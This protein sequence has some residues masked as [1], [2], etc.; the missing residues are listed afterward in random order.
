MLKHVGWLGLLLLVMPVS[1]VEP[2]FSDLGSDVV[3]V[4]IT[5]V[6]DC[7]AACGTRSVRAGDVLTAEQAEKLELTA[8]GKADRTAEVVYLPVFADGVGQEERVSVFLRGTEDEKPV[9]QDSAVETYKNIAV[10]AAPHCEDPEGGEL[11]YTVVRAPKRGTVTWQA[12]GTF[13]Y[14]PKDE[15]VGEDYFTYVAEDAAGN[16][17]AEAKVSVTILQCS[18]SDVFADMVG[19]PQELAAVFLRKHDIF[20]GTEIGE[21]TCFCPEQ[22]VSY[23][24][25]LMMLMKQTGLEAER[26]QETGWFAPWQTAALRAGLTAKPEQFDRQTAA[27]LVAEILPG[28]SDAE[29]A[30]IETGNFA[31]AKP[32]T[33]REAARMLYAVHCYCTENDVVFPWQ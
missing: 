12:D 15:K 31:E 14:T 1:A 23:E 26:T 6:S 25:F 11:I 17:S 22:T 21:L 33:R 10:T 27:A 20:S 13:T 3:G 19:D 9:A 7:L 2:C 24:E 30:W 5:E 8:N 4:C 32:L 28:S 16:C 29:Q 18:S